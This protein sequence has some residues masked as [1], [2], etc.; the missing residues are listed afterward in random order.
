MIDEG[1][2]DVFVSAS[3]GLE[4][5]ARDY[6]SRAARSLAVVCLSGIARTSADFHDLAIAL[7][8]DRKRPRRVVALDYR[9]RGRSAYDREWRRYEVKVELADVL[10]VL[11]ALGVSE[12]VFIGT[13][14]GGIIT[15]AL[16][17]IR[18]AM[19]KG[20]VLNDIGPVIE[21][22][23]L[24][25]IRGY[26]GK[27]PLPASYEEGAQILKN[28]MSAQFTALGDED[29]LGYARGTWRESGEGLVL[30]YDP[31]LM[32]TL[33]AV[34]LE[35]PL[36]PL[37]PLFEGLKR[38]PLLAVRGEN[39]DIL[40]AETLAAMARAHLRLTAV[41]VPAQGHAP[42][43]KGRDLV[44]QIRRFIAKIEADET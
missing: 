40:S 22:K 17:A 24:A 10:D 23:G 3:D 30:D 35:R 29:W 13:S 41:T 42:L 14:R 8:G 15:M 39:S 16:S 5:Y 37:W 20:A 7:S 12:A 19:I 2:A 21:G 32:R 33:E 31:L 36:P 1:F 25:R 28:L 9:G 44:Q 11:T 18:P 34:D 27:L 26:V 4:L 6:G 38:V 43:L